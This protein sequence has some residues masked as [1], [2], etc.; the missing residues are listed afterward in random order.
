MSGKRASLSLMKKYEIIKEAEIARQHGI[1][2]STLS[3]ILKMREEIVNL[4]NELLKYL[5]LIYEIGSTV[6]KKETCLQHK[7]AKIQSIQDHTSQSRPLFAAQLIRRQLDCHWLRRKM[8]K[9]FI[10][11]YFSRL[12]VSRTCVLGS[13]VSLPED[14][15]SRNA[16]FCRVWKNYCLCEFLGCDCFIYKK[17]KNATAIMRANSRDISALGPTSTLSG[18]PNGHAVNTSL[19][20]T[21][22]GDAEGVLDGTA[23]DVLN[24]VVLYKVLVQGL[25]LL[26]GQ[27]G[28]VR[29]QI[30]LG[31]ELFVDDGRHVQQRVAHPQHQPLAATP[32]AHILA[33]SSQ[34]INTLSKN[35]VDKSMYMGRHY[36]KAPFYVEIFSPCLRKRSVGAI[37]AKLPRTSSSLSSQGSELACSALVT[38]R[39]HKLLTSDEQTSCR[40]LRN[41][42][43]ISL[44]RVCDLVTFL[45]AGK[46]TVRQC[47]CNPDNACADGT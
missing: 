21:N 44:W 23:G 30:V 19:S 14:S 32:H 24:L 8:V 11:A 27:D 4:C 28:V 35:I 10:N 5:E 29:L 40:L 18:Q 26:S 16:A 20:C 34:L 22:L 15:S 47:G 9:T 2:K 6:I 7:T 43:R 33:P 45:A 42:Q 25:V 39:F 37:R 31:E 36:F 3:T 12:L 41:H 17:A 1:P 13:S 38:L 46:I